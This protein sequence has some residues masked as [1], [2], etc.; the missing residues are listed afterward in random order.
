MNLS[1]TTI[2]L[3]MALVFASGAAIGV[4]GNRYYQASV[5]T[6]AKGKGR[7]PPTQDEF[8]KM[9]LANMQKQ[10]LLSDDQ[11][12][13]LTGILE[14]TRRLMN[15]LHQ[16]QAPEQQELQRSQNAKIRAL[17]DAVQQDKY[18]AMM[19]RLSERAKNKANKTRPGF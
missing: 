17:L 6:A 14:E 19:K 15:D 10:L 16:R 11:V 5:Q 4:F 7:R 13:K 12:Q 8:R 18:D 2:A 1:R 3:Y 9:Y